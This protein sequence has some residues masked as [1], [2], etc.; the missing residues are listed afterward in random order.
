MLPDKDVMCHRTGFEKSCFALVTEGKCKRW[1]NIQGE[2]PQTGV[3]MNHWDC[4]DNL[5]PLLLI[6]LGRQQNETTASV[7]KACN[8]GAKRSDE[9]LA[10]NAAALS[11]AAS[12][13]QRIDLLPRAAVDALPN[14]SVRMLEHRS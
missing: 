1:Q 10:L 5:I 8:E 2:H 12:H 4:A 14:A 7:D 13:L 6:N 11:A 3:Q 9:L